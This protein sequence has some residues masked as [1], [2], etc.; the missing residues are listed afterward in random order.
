MSAARQAEL[1]RIILAGLPGSDFAY[2]RAAFLDLLKRFRRHD[3]RTTCSA[4]LADFHREVVPV[5]EEAGIR[6]AIHPDDPPIPLF[7]LPRI[8]STASDARGAARRRRQP[9]ERPHLLRRLLRL[10]RA[11]TTSSP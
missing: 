4:S 10:A 8:V 9:G 6:L 7:G 2:D 1:E 5:A 11:T 3:G